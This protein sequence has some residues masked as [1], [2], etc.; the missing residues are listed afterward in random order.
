MRL[1]QILTQEGKRLQVRSDEGL[2]TRMYRSLGGLVEGWSK[3]ISIGALQAF[4]G[5]LR[6]VIL[7][8]SFSLGFVLWLFPLLILGWAL[9]T[10][11]GGMPLVFAAGAA[12]FGVVFWGVM[13]G[14]MGASPLFGVLFPLA[15]VLTA[16]IFVLSWRRGGRVRW[17]GRSYD[18]STHGRG[19]GTAAGDAPGEPGGPPSPT[20]DQE[21]EGVA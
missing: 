12:G 19:D 1:A 17:K 18:L 20:D 8:L 11:T 10:G 3:N 5:F 9:A 7:P 4:P 6:P 16:Y 13:Y 2:R 14:V 15:S 21:R